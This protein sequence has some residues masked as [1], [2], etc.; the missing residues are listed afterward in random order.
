MTI[1]DRNRECGPIRFGAG[2]YWR[3]GPVRLDISIGVFSTERA[4][5]DY[6]AGC[7]CIQVAAGQLF[8]R[9][10]DGTDLKVDEDDCLAYDTDILALDHSWCDAALPWR[11]L[12]AI[13]TSDVPFACVG[14]AAL[15]VAP[16]VQPTPR[17]VIAGATDL[18][19]IQCGQTAN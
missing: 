10:A 18:M 9:M 3:Q 15:W 13:M 8:L 1:Q 5:L 2:T 6:A 19:P 12:L 17:E 14:R 4:A 7:G 11:E 16:D